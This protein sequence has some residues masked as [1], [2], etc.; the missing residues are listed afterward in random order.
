MTI[1][2]VMTQRPAQP[3]VAIPASV[4]MQTLGVVV[5]PLT[6]ELFGWIAAR[7]IASA[8]PPFWRYT[9]IDMARRRRAARRVLGRDRTSFLGP[10][11]TGVTADRQPAIRRH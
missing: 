9:L 3:Y 7:G 5:P 4:T 11:R 2:P 1:E 8:G 6:G 10:A